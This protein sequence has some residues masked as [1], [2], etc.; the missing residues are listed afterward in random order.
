MLALT[1]LKNCQ[2]AQNRPFPT[3]LRFPLAHLPTAPLTRV[4]LID[5]SSM[6][7]SPHPS[8]PARRTCFLHPHCHASPAHGSWIRPKTSPS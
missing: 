7:H 5:R 2:L 4:S 3:G 6:I 1:S 8:P